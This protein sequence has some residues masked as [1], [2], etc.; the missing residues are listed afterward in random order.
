MTDT[1]Q[2]SINTWWGNLS[3]EEREKLIGRGSFVLY[4][5]RSLLVQSIGRD[6][7]TGQLTYY[8]DGW[9]PEARHCVPS[10]GC[11]AFWWKL[12][13]KLIDQVYHIHIWR[14]FRSKH[15]K[16]CGRR[17]PCVSGVF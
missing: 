15:Y 6:T 9:S 12:E 17:V 1:L 14:K 2:P 16:P 5:G 3:D 11:N 7:N 10:A 8:C 4:N 13:E